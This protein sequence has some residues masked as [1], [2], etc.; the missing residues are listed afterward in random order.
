MGKTF[1]LDPI[2]KR[3]PKNFGEED[4]FYIKD[5]HELIISQED[6]DKVQAIRF[7]R[8]KN[9][10][11]V[12]SKNRKRDKFSRKYA[13]S[14]LLEC[15]FCRSNLSRRFWHNNFQYKKNIWQCVTGIKKGKK[16]FPNSKGIEETTIEKAFLQGINERIR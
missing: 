2:T 14:C 11:T 6:F 9:R 12:G 1:T 13:F 3:R 15:G 8:A 10:N 16:F 7:R 4:K 5:H